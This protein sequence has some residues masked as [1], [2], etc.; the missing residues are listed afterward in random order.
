MSVFKV[1]VIGALNSD[2]SVEGRVNSKALKPKNKIINIKANL[3]KISK[4]LKAIFINALMP[5]IIR[6]ITR[7]ELDWETKELFIV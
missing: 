2:E 6:I 4:S 3:T 1:S 5:K 7:K